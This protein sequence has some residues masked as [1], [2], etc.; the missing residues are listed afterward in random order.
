MDKQN[1]LSTQE[2]QIQD[3]LSVFLRSKAST[4]AGNAHSVHLE[5]DTMSAFV[6]GTLSERESAPVIGHLARCS[7]CRHVTAELVRLDMEFAGA[8]AVAR[9][10]ETEETSKVSDVLSKILSRIFGTNDGAVF[11]HSED[12]DDKSDKSESENEK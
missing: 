11:A 6:D 5:D 12:Q 4:D 8:T 2:K 9:N 7:F 3:L 1:N 10:V